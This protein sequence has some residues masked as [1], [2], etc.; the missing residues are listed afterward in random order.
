[1]PQHKSAV[2]DRFVSERYAQRHPRTT[3]QLGQKQKG[4]PA[5]RKKR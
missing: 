3:Y 4:K 5:R 2:D 1:M